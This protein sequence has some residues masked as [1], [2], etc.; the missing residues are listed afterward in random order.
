M[1]RPAPGLCHRPSTVV[2]TKFSTG[3]PA[4]MPSKSAGNRWASMRRLAPARRAAVPVRERHRAVV[5]TRRHGL[6]GDRG[7]V[8]GPERV[9]DDLLIAPLG[10]G[11]QRLLRRL[12]AGVGGRGDEAVTEGGGAQGGPRRRLRR[13]AGEAT[14]AVHVEAAVPRGREVHLEADLRG[15]Q[16]VDPAVL[17]HPVGACHDLRRDDRYVGVGHAEQI[18][19][20]HLRP[21][22]RPRVTGGRA[23][24]IGEAEAVLSPRRRHGAE[25]EQHGGEDAPAASRHPANVQRGSAAAISTSGSFSSRRTM[26]APRLMA[27]DL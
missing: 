8:H 12:V 19:A 2:S 3:A 25:H 15:Q 4:T 7:Q 11:R 20:G 6:G 23:G 17:G 24:S 10:E 16:P 14:V 5:V 1:P 13:F 21:H 18:A 27:T 26:L 9:V 22:G